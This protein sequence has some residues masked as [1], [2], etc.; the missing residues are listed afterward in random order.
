MRKLAI[1]MDDTP[2]SPKPIPLVYDTFDPPS[3][4]PL[5]GHFALAS[6]LSS[7]VLC[8][9]FAIYR[10]RVS[11]G[12]ETEGALL[13]GVLFAA[14]L[15]NS[16]SLVLISMIVHIRRTISGC[17]MLPHKPLR[18]VLVGIGM[19]WIAGGLLWAFLFEA[20][21]NHLASRQAAWIGIACSL[22]LPILI[23]GWLLPR[24]RAQ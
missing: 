21:R 1:S 16:V 17:A 7:I 13:L 10:F 2:S 23:G 19:P 15:W 9:A 3:I 14:V 20:E 4:V 11:G 24:F 18:A 8:F 6:C 5:V 12:F 22:L